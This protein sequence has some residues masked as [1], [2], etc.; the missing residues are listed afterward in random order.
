MTGIEA[1]INTAN[2]TASEDT[3]INAVPASASIAGS[4]YADLNNNGF[5]EPNETGIANVLITLGGDKNESTLTDANGNYSFDGLQAGTYTVAE[6]QPA[7]FNDGIENSRSGR[8]G[9]RVSDD[10]F[11]NLVLG[12]GVAATGFNFGEIP[13]MSSV[14]NGTV[15]CDAD[16]DSQNDP[17]EEVPGTQVFIDANNNGRFDSGEP[18][19]TTGV[20]G[21]YQFDNV[22]GPSVTVLVRV[23][24][25]C[26]TIPDE[27]SVRR[28]SVPV[29][30]GARSITA[31]DIDNDGD[32]DLLVASDIS[33]SMTVVENKQAFFEDATTIPLGDRPHSISAFRSVTSGGSLVTVAVA[34]VGTPNDVGALYEWNGQGIPVR[35]P[36]PAGPIDVIV[37]DF[38]E[39]GR[40]D[41]ITASFRESIVTLDLGTGESFSV[42]S[43]SDQILSIATGDL[44]GA[45]MTKEL[46]VSGF[47]F[48]DTTRL[49]VF[50]VNDQ[51]NIIK[52]DSIDT[53]PSI[54]EVSVQQVIGGSGS[55]QNEIVVLHSSGKIVV[56]PMIGGSIGTPIETR[57]VPGASAFDFGDF[58]K[59]GIVDVAVANL[60]GQFVELYSGNGNG[61]FRVGDHDSQCLGPG[62]SGR[63]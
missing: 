6:D 43:L 20:N 15:F 35:Q 40:H 49:E 18:S 37:D 32:L 29:G 45:N 19:T 7:G 3:Q 8:L 23:P 28:S 12:Q 53:D 36:G 62:R 63:R 38:D 13:P 39:D 48:G 31:V 27:P 25:N 61:N 21:E 51:G 14:V 47:G 41:I 22:I 59:D 9:A 50:G 2:N 30:K 44:V 60:G 16:R 34:G 10:L 26:N 4:V 33:D 54:V 57:I 17:G 24:P 55:L 58:N 52:L 1:E 42:N 56:Y 46:V 11:T 5:R